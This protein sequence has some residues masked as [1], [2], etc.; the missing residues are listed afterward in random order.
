MASRTVLLNIQPETQ[1]QSHQ[2]SN[3]TI[4]PDNKLYVHLGDG[5]NFAAAQNLDQYRGKILR[6]NLDG[7]AD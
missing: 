1:G 4:G 2:I 7:T 5:F 3:V 6:M